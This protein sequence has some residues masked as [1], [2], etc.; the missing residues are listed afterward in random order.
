MILNWKENKEAGAISFEIRIPRK[1]NKQLLRKVQS[2]NYGSYFIME[3]NN[4][5]FWFVNNSE[6]HHRKMKLWLHKFSRRT[7]CFSTS[8]VGFTNSSFKLTFKINSFFFLISYYHH[9][10]PEIQVVLVISY[11]LILFS[12]SMSTTISLSCWLSQLYVARGKIDWKLISLSVVHLISWN[13]PTDF[14][15]TISSSIFLTVPPGRVSHQNGWGKIY[16]PKVEIRQSA[17]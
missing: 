9:Y 5:I 2:K 1:K 17:I 6:Y 12:V 7:K 16:V 4:N 15:I 3:K 11:L 13:C 14:Q 8:K 10:F